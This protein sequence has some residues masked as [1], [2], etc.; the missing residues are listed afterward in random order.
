MPVVH[1]C[2]ETTCMEDQSIAGC[3]LSSDLFTVT[4]LKLPTNSVLTV[5]HIAKS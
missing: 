2:S 5:K 1:V 4:A 3:A